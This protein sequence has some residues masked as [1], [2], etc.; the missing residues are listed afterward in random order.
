[1]NLKEK[2]GD[3]TL[4][5]Y[6]LEGNQGFSRVGKKEGFRPGFVFRDEKGNKSVLG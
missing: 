4:R 5:I 1:M 2:R 3:V 6:N